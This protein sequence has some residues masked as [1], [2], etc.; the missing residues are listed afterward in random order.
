MGRKGFE[1][2]RSWLRDIKDVAREGWSVLAVFWAPGLVGVMIEIE[3]S[4]H[5][6]HNWHW[7]HLSPWWLGVFLLGWI[8]ASH[9]VLRARG[10][11]PAVEEHTAAVQ[12]AM[13]ALV[14]DLVAQGAFATLESDGLRLEARAAGR[15]AEP[16]TTAA[17]IIAT[18]EIVGESTHLEFH[19]HS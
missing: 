18:L 4:I 17:M 1:T 15:P 14:P 3:H 6:D 13:V 12:R 9:R 2:V 11:A 7:P 8:V 10:R 5:A 19:R 16:D